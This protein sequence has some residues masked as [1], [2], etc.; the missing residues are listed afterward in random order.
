M[1]DANN[2]RMSRFVLWGLLALMAVAGFVLLASVFL[3]T[4]LEGGPS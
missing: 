3:G 4:G 2:D 1:D